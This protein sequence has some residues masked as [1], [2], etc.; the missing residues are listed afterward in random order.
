MIAAHD[1]AFG[2]WHVERRLRELGLNRHQEDG[3]AHELGEDVGIADRSPAEDFAV[4]LRQDDLLK[5]ERA[6]LDDNAHHSQHQ[7][8]LIGDQLPGSP[9]PADEGV[10]VGRSPARHQNPHH[11]KRRHR[12]SVEHSRVQVAHDGIRTHR[13]HHIQQKSAHQHHHGSRREN[14]PVGLLGEDVF[15]LEEFQPVGQ[16]L[17]SAVRPGFHRAQSALH[18]AHHLQQEHIT[19]YERSSRN[20]RSHHARF[21][22]SLLPISQLS[23][24]ARS[25]QAFNHLSMSPKMK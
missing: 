16:Q 7:R 21:D 23:E 15:F 18:E 13:Q 22:D 9:Q 5:V 3:E 2:H 17:Q 12:Q 4:G 6:R 10:F 20:H 19:Q 14:E 1:L 24:Y 25:K 11:R 8:Q